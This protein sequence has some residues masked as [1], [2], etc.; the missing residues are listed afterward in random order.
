[1]RLVYSK[2]CIYLSNENLKVR[3]TTTNAEAEK[4]GKD[5]KNIKDKTTTTPRY[6]PILR[7]RKSLSLAYGNDILSAFM[8]FR[9]AFTSVKNSNKFFIY[10][11]TN[12]RKKNYNSLIL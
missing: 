10:S 12:T 1:M 2:Y 11:F 3:E 8:R 7:S 6:S 9:C 5:G 4:F